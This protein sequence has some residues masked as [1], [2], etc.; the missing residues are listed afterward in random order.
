V[1]DEALILSQYRNSQVDRIQA[2]N[3]LHV[4]ANTLRNSVGLPVGAPLELVER[5]ENQISLAPVETLREEARRKRPEVAQDE[6]R[7]RAAEQ[8]QSIARI[9]RKPR[10]NTNFVFN[11]NPNNPA[12]RSNYAISANVSV[13]VFDGGLTEAQERVAKSQ[14]Q[15]AA[16]QLEQ[17]KK[18]VASDVEQAYL[19]LVNARER[20]QAARLAVDAS[21]VNLEAATARY[22][23]GAAGTTVVDLI[24]AQV[25][26]ATASNSAITALYDVQLAQAQ[27]DRATGR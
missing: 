2:E 10:I 8:G 25:Q 9:A 27:L 21:R 1:A 26:F 5:A 14:I 7:V 22:R 17:T 3:D 11:V 16:A 18:D 24:Q 15:A 20:L 4:S 12:D 19:N 13:P 6:A 23:L